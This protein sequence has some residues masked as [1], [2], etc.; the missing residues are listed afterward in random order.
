MQKCPRTSLA[1]KIRK[2]RIEKGLSQKA[3]AD[4]LGISRACL[5]NY[6]TGNRQPDNE[7]L[8]RI[9]DIFNVLID[10][11]VDRTEFRSLDLTSEEI[12]A[13][14]RLKY[15]LANRGNILDLSPLTIENRIAVIQYYDFVTG[16]HV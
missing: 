1:S 11:L 15:A 8:V 4:K 14:T 13:F 12:V 9:A 7:M 6:E 3:L 10:Y 2:L 5:A 16:G